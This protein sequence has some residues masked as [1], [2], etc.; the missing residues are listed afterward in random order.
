MGGTDPFGLPA[1]LEAIKERN[2]RIAALE[3]DL[4]SARAERKNISA[5]LQLIQAER[6]KLDAD[7]AEARKVSEGRLEVLNRKADELRSEWMRAEKAESEAAR[8]REVVIGYQVR[9][10]AA[11]TKSR[12]NALTKERDALRAA[13]RGIRTRA[14]QTGADGNAELWNLCVNIAKTVS[15]ALSPPPA[16]ACK[17]RVVNRHAIYYPGRPGYWTGVCSDCGESLSSEGTAK[18]VGGSTTRPAPNPDIPA[19]EKPSEHRL[20]VWC[21]NCESVIALNEAPPA[22]AKGCDGILTCLEDPKFHTHTKSCYEHCPACP[23]A[24]R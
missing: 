19:A 3:A 23:E 13:L 21:K 9:H 14:R 16:T 18:A 2:A 15:E 4:A 12:E 11:Y 17:H 7:L 22:P 20:Q 10:D 1:A 8:L 5:N 24:E 6:D